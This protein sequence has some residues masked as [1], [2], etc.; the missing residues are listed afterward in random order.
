[1]FNRQLKLNVELVHYDK[2][3]MVRCE[4]QLMA[5]RFNLATCA[6]S[7]LNTLK[8]EAGPLAE[9][10]SPELHLVCCTCPGPNSPA[11]RDVRVG[12]G[13]VEDIISSLPIRTGPNV[14]LIFVCRAFL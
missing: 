5:E 10:K 9:R 12:V 14:F 6:D 11:R 3:V 2:R 4:T 1:M 7:R 13:H 8:G